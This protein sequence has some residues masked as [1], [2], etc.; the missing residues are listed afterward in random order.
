M[1]RLLEATS[2]DGLTD[3]TGREAL[4]ACLPVTCKFVAEARNPRPKAE[5]KKS[6]QNN[7]SYPGLQ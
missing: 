6:A 3:G 7:K 5:A 4:R 1:F 2:T